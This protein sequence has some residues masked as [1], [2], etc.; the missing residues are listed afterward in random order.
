MNEV[1]E[2]E[3]QNPILGAPRRA[4][5]SPRDEVRDGDTKGIF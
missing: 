1:D 2:I 4:A 5:G 3:M